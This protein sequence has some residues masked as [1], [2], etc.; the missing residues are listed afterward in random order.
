MKKEYI[1]NFLDV[2][3][4]ELIRQFADNEN[5]IK[6]VEKVLLAGIYNSGVLRKGKSVDPLENFALSI[7]CVKGV[8]NEEIGA[9][10]KACWE[11]INAL[12][13]ALKDI[14]MYKS[15]EAPKFKQNPAR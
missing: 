10:V 15:I 13:L 2:N 4:Q 11:G 14:R 9:D 7:A 3:E 5:M 12:E 1:D 6:A 8:S